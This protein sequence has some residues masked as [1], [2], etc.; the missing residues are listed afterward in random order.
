MSKHLELFSEPQLKQALELVH[1]VYDEKTFTESHVLCASN[2]GVLLSV[3][4]PGIIENSKFTLRLLDLFYEKQASLSNVK[5]L[6]RDVFK[7]DV[8]TEYNVQISR[9]LSIYYDEQLSIPQKLA[10]W[11]L[12]NEQQAILLNEQQAILLNEQQAIS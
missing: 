2:L 11:G 1:A 9:F 12:L 10:L 6:I 4:Y 8:S 5:D 7:Q 3:W